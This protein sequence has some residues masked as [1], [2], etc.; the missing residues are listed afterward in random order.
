MSCTHYVCKLG[1]MRQPQPPVFL[2]HRQLTS[3]ETRPSSMAIKPHP[4]IALVGA[5]LLQLEQFTQ[6]ACHPIIMF[7]QLRS[8][9]PQTSSPLWKHARATFPSTTAKKMEKMTGSSPKQWGPTA[10]TSTRTKKA[11]K[12]RQELRK[13]KPGSSRGL[14]V[15]FFRLAADPK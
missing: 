12:I 2:K 13:I 10:F 14:N 4:I 9:K 5:C 15:R 7:P 1:R 11:W 6:S 8:R 3:K